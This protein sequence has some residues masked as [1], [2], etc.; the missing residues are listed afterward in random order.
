M[1]CDV[2]ITAITVRMRTSCGRR[3][4]TIQQYLRQIDSLRDSLF[5]RF[6]AQNV[7]IETRE[8]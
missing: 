2:A 7:E 3:R 4:S 6:R 5:A 8:S 1:A